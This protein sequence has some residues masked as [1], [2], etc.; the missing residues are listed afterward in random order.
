M[1]TE[2]WQVEFVAYSGGTKIRVSA[3]NPKE[4]IKK[5]LSYAKREEMTYHRLQDICS[6][7][8]VAETTT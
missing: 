8:C 5:A 6:V 7:E 1:S 2:I 3:H 4:A